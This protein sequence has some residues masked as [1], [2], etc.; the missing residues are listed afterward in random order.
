[1]NLPPERDKE[2]GQ[3]IVGQNR[4]SNTL[5]RR[6]CF[7]DSTLKL[8]TENKQG[9]WFVVS[10]KKRWNAREIDRSNK[11]AVLYHTLSEAFAEVARRLDVHPS[12]QYGIFECIGKTSVSEWRKLKKQRLAE[13]G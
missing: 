5:L 1:M 2:E 7:M 13:K 3:P 11:P 6:L 10:M 8:I 12:Q 9:P 4:R